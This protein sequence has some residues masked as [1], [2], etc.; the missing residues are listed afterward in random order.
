[1]V[2]PVTAAATLAV[3]PAGQAVVDG[4]PATTIGALG[5]QPRRVI[6]LSG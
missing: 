1:M 6:P 5:A 2:L 4:L 3:L